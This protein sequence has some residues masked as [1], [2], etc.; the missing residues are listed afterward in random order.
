MNIFRLIGDLSHLL[1]ILILLFKIHASGICTGLSLKSQILYVIV[2]ITRYSDLITN[3]VSYYN[4]LMKIF[5]IVSSVYTVY[6]IKF[7]F[8]ETYDYIMD[9][10][11]IEFLLIGS[12]ILALFFPYKY[13]VLEIL[14]VFSICLESVAILPQLFMLRRTGDAEPFTTL[15]IYVLG[16]YRGFYILNWIYRYYSEEYIDLIS[17]IAGILQTT[18]YIDFFYVYYSTL[19][20]TVHD[21]INLQNLEEQIDGD[22]EEANMFLEEETSEQH[23]NYQTIV[24]KT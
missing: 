2:F 6:L 23:I 16:V 9:T 24:L 12:A 3:F 10:F 22:I 20:K 18:L 14:W 13:S 17:L 5:F 11:R 19:R 4:T 7:H 8:K 1:S 21:L 15:Y